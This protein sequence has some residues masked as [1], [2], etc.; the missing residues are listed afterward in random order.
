VMFGNISINAGGLEMYDALVADGRVVTQGI[1]FDV[2]SDRLRAE[3][4]PTLT[5]IVEM[6]RAHPELRL[7]IEGHTDGTGD[8]ARNQS[9]SERRAAAVRTYLTTMG[10]LDAGRL[11]SQGF[12]ASRAVA[13]ND[14]PEGRQQNRRVE[15]V[16]LD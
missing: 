11:E 10:N 9:L 14:T 6:L 8:A 1:L 7:R 4:T 16:R 15:L 12:G 13:P 2:D 5:A 3:S